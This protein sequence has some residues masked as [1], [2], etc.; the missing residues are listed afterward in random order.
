[1]DA[2]AGPA[3]PAF[4]AFASADST[5][6]W[7]LMADE[8]ALLHPRAVQQR[9]ESFRLG[10]A[11]AHAALRAVGRDGEAVLTGD[12]RQPIWP[13]GVVG[14]ISHT[15]TLG[16]AVVAHDK[17]SDGVGV[18]IERLR[19]APE[20]WDQVPVREEQDWLRAM[21][22]PQQDRALLALFSAKESVFK[23]F[24]PRVGRFFGFESA[25]L[26]PTPK[27]FT[28]HLVAGLDD[29][30][31]PDRTFDVPTRWSG[32]TVITAVVLP[33]PT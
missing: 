27:G 17:L 33:R 30:Y 29:G 22:P 21:P 6:T 2:I 19:F 28:G 24:F 32:K 5:S 13:S 18:D 25:I 7:E 11:A 23:A 4:A 9:R 14:S 3:L 1:M 8:A 31:P 26:Q 12:Q 15:S 20:L 10:R 16:V